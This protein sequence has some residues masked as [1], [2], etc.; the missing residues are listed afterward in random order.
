MAITDHRFVTDTCTVT[1]Y[2]NGAAIAVNYGTRDVQINGQTVAASS[3]AR[4]KER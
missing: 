1:T 3:F 4:L 2:E